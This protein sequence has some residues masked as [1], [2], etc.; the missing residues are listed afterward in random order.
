RELVARPLADH[1]ARDVADVVLV[2]HEQRAEARAR[3]GLP[4]AAEPVGVQPPEV[5]A[6]LEVHLH[7]TGRVQRPIPAM[8][9]ADRVRSHGLAGGCAVLAGH[10]VLRATPPH[11]TP[12]RLRSARRSAECPMRV[13]IS[14]V[15][16]P[17]FGAGARSPPGVRSRR[18]TGACMG[19]VPISS[20]GGSTT[21]PRSCTCGSAR[22]WPM[23]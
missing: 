20:S 23:S 7:V 10:D 6:L 21:I 14:A 19:T 5:D 22:N 15:C 3:E 13:K 11:P 17:S 4:H 9:G 16:W 8:P 12:R 2:E 18:G 1:G